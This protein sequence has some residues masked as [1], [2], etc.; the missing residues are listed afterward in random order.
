MVTFSVF[1]LQQALLTL[2]QHQE[3]F[4]EE[5][6]EDEKELHRRETQKHQH[7]RRKERAKESEKTT[8]SWREASDSHFR[9]N[10]SSI[11]LY[12]IYTFIR[13]IAVLCVLY[14]HITYDLILQMTSF[15]TR[16]HC[17][18]TRRSSLSCTCEKNIKS[19]KCME[20]IT[21]YYYCF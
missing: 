21:Y 17:F 15:S 4:A 18:C 9:D 6:R 12:D 8:V 20:F 10:S 7:Q 5:E 2:R 1:Q 14:V 13:I 11:C 16:W 3:V 19:S